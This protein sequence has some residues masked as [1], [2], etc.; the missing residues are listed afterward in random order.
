MIVDLD[1]TDCGNRLAPLVATWSDEVV[2][3]RIELLP[4][5]SYSSRYAWMFAYEKGLKRRIERALG[6]PLGAWE[7]R[8]FGADAPFSEGL[9]NAFLHGNRHDP[10]RTI[11]VRTAVSRLGLAFAIH[12]DGDGFDVARAFAALNS[13]KAYFQVAGNGL[14]TFAVDSHV[15]A[16]YT[17]GGR[18]LILFAPFHPQQRGGARALRAPA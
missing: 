2:P 7:R 18:S 4:H 8:L 15:S 14:R 12:D 1:F 11:E 10:L 16:A 3:Q 13:G 5:S 17:D 9:S 6:H